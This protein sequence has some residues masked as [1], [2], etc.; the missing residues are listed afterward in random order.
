MS[1]VC[2]ILCTETQKPIRPRP[3]PHGCRVWW[4]AGRQSQRE[5]AVCCRGMKG[6]QGRQ[7]WFPQSQHWACARNM[8]GRICREELYQA[9]GIIARAELWQSVNC[10]PT[11]NLHV[12]CWQCPT[13]F[14]GAEEFPLVLYRIQEK[15]PNNMSQLRWSVFVPV[16]GLG[17]GIKLR[18]G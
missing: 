9:K 18:F 5:N 12:S 16:I 3:C 4:E 6:P 8:W 15:I 14:W 13:Y 11:A 10:P 1:C 2:S 17:M 7:G